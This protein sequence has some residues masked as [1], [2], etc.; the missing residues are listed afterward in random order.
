MEADGMSHQR[1]PVKLQGMMP[2]VI[3]EDVPANYWNRV[4]NVLFK[5][6]ETVRI[7]QDFPTLPGATTTP[8]VCVFNNFQLGRYWVYANENGIWAHDGTAE[9]EITPDTGWTGAFDPDVYWTATI[10]GGIV[11]INASDRDPVFWGGDTAN[12]AAPLPDWPSG[13]RCNALRAHKAFLFAIGIDKNLGQRVR[14]SDAA[15]PGT[16]PQHWTPAADNLA[17]FVDLAPTSAPAFDGAPMRDSFIVYKTE[18]LWSFDFIGGNDVFAAR[19]G[20]RCCR[21][22]R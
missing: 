5:N 14:W 7:A 20:P 17:G 13:E 12:K 2:D 6:G 4:N 10:L 15:E 9:T 16:V 18:S 22:R 19:K 3:A 1:M 8:R 21:L 11:Y